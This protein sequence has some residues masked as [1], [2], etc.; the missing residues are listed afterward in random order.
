M[1][2]LTLGMMTRMMDSWDRAW[3]EEMSIFNVG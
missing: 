1:A 3:L 2:V